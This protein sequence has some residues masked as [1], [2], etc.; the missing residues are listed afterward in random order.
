M[1][2]LTDV[3]FFLRRFD[4]IL[5][6]LYCYSSFNFKSLW[7][8]TLLFMF[9]LLVSF[10]AL[11]QIESITKNENQIITK[12]QLSVEDGL[13]GR[14]VL[15]AVEDK[16]GYMWF[17]TSNGLSRYDGNTFK[18]FTI[19]N[20]GLLENEINYLSIDDKNHLIIR[21]IDHNN[22]AG[23]YVPKI[24]VLDL[25]TYTLHT[26]DSI[27]SGMPFKSKNVLWIANDAHQD[28]I[29]LT[30][31]PF[32]LWSFTPA[33]GFQLRANL[34]EWGSCKTLTIIQ[35]ATIIESSILQNGNILLSLQGYPNYLVTKDA[36]T[37]FS[38]IKDEN[39]VGITK[40]SKFIT[41]NTKSQSLSLQNFPNS[42]TKANTKTAHVLKSNVSSVAKSISE[43]YTC[44]RDSKRGIYLVEEKSTILIVKPEEFSNAIN[45]KIYNIY[46]DSQRNHWLCTTNGVIQIT[47]NPNYFKSY[48]TKQEEKA[49]LYNQVRGIYVDTGGA[50]NTGNSNT[51]VYANVW[52]YLCIS[53]LK[54]NK[55]TV[56]KTIQNPSLNAFL[57]QKDNFYIGGVDAIYQYIPQQ[58]KLNT[59]LALPY[60][61]YNKY[62]WALTATSDS[63]LLAGHS[64]GIEK[65]NV[66]T[67]LNTPIKYK[68]PKIPK[69]L[70]V[71]RFVN[72]KNKGLIAVAENGL[73]LIDRNNVIVDYY[74]NLVQD[75]LHHL[76]IG[77]LLDMH[78][79]SKGICWI[80]TN[81][82]GLFRWDWRQSNPKNAILVKQ[83]SDKN[84]L[85][86]AI[87]YR[88][89]EDAA[90]NLWISS[91][92]GLIRFN[93]VTYTTSIYTTDDGLTHNEFNRTSSY[94]AADGTLYFGGLD[95]LIAFHPKQ[96]IASEI[97]KKSKLIITA[98]TKYSE[99]QTKKIDCLIELKRNNKIELHPTDNFL[100]ID[101]QLLDFKNRKHLY[102]YKIDGI[103]TEWNYIDENTIRLNNLPYGEFK[104]RIKAQLGNGKWNSNTID[105]SIRV[106]KPFYLENWFLIALVLVI[107]SVVVFY[108][109]Y[110]IHKAQK[111]KEQLELKITERTTELK[112]ALTDRELL[113]K[114]VHHRV[115][116]NLHVINSL[117]EL[118]KVEFQDPILK[119]AFAEGQSRIESIALIHQNLY[120]KEDLVSIE[121]STFIHELTSNVAQLFK[122]STSQVLFSINKEK[123]YLDVDTAIPLGLIV[124]ELVTNSYK[125]FDAK[126]KN[127]S[128]SISIKLIAK[129]QYDLVYQDNG[130]G[131]PGTINFDTDETLGLKLIK[132]LAKQLAGKATYHYDNGSVFTI[133]FQDSAQRYDN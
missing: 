20:F 85:P 96:L 131:L 95:G 106:L 114:E 28:L 105:F 67:K 66:L 9:F 15:C 46:K 71:Y 16:E 8:S 80:A 52:D 31:Q 7:K 21:Y 93:A 44:V 27:Y 123:L 55:P 41:Y 89:E 92:A 35:V 112:K 62:V 19:Q 98:V 94:K 101:F 30:A 23:L 128:I 113:L 61:H 127:N 3:L 32:Q 42:T 6:S 107:S 22:I 111:D 11:A 24:Q 4:E 75:K 82:E 33:K 54:T 5:F 74:G 125:N 1:C 48:F 120:Q 38:A 13:A 50:L 126:K 83:F 118:Q 58:N 65:Y 119:A 10:P 110:R 122:R 88:I 26:L 91:Y 59:I 124:N 81:G 51:T 70:N 69:S 36:V 84:G 18:T 108:F 29:F 56:S 57:K 73:Y 17:G 86:S 87:L 109:R 43:Q 130:N 34:T 2:K 60:Q 115:K 129:G 78:E 40:N 90:N 77:S 45:F 63:I 25:N 99:D 72:T 76:P 100:I 47:I 49:P 132:G 104:L 12:R 39:V 121:F 68:T 97:N 116:N 53:N 79:D 14:E 102:A 64:E 37:T 103:D 133:F 117:L